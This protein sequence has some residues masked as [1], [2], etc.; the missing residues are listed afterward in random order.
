MDVEIRQATLKD[1]AGIG[2][3]LEEV[4]PNRY[5][6]PDR[7]AW[8]NLQNPLIPKGNGLPTLLAIGDGR[9]VGHDGAMPVQVKICD[10][11]LNAAWG[12]DSVVS[13]ASHGLGIGTKLLT[14]NH[15]S[16]QLLIALELTETS[17]A[18]EKK[19]GARDGPVVSLLYLT[20]HILPLPVL[21]EISEHV[22][23]RFGINE[24]FVNYGAKGTGLLHAQCWILKKR[25]QKKQRLPKSLQEATNLT[26]ESITRFDGQ[27][28]AL[29]AAIRSRYTFAVE[30]SSAYMNWKYFDQPH[31]IHHCFYVREQGS[32]K[33]ILVI[34]Q[35]TPPE[36]NIGVICECYLSDPDPVMYSWVIQKAV[37]Q[38]TDQGTAGVWAATAD[39]ELEDIFRERG[40]LQIRQA[41]MTVHFN[42]NMGNDTDI[43]ARPLMGKGDHDWDQFP[44]LRQPSFGQF[45]K[46]AFERR[47]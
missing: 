1:A 42:D 14:A 41:T 36:H 43:F 2:I 44:N 39:R 40:F 21:Q 32:V 20:D 33:G 16:Y 12:L 9:I 35:G 4:F 30:R 22:R 13:S 23:R 46:L 8:L 10:R 17:R 45:I 19:L 6:Y 25:I 27:A 11:T 28:D 38:L 31:M 24:S 37:T 47:R 34:R 15:N 18:I 3:F 29:W 5:R 7:W 26:L